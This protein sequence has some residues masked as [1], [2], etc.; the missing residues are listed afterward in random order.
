MI[1]G[2][3]SP[4]IGVA[5]RS[6]ASGAE[7]GLVNFRR[8]ITV[9]RAWLPLM[10]VTAVLA[11]ATA[12]V[13]SSAMPKVYEAET[14]LIVGQ[15]LSAANPDYSQF[16]VD[17]S[18]SS[19]YAAVAK[20]RPILESVI[21]KLG[22]ADTPGELADRVRVDAPQSSS[23]LLIKVQDTDPARAAAIANELGDQLIAASP[24][25]RGRTS[26]V[27]TGVDVDLAATREV[28]ASLQ[29]QAK[30]LSD[31][32]ART[33][34]QD[35][36][37]QA[38]VE[39]LVNIRA[40]YATLLSYASGGEANVLTVIEPAAPTTSPVAP[41]TL[42]NTLLAAVLGL[43][44]VAGI[45][46]LAEQL[47][48]TV[49]D[50]DDVQEVANLGTLGTIARMRDRG[51]DEIYRVVTLLYPRSSIAEAYRALRVNVEFASVD[52]PL[53]TLLVTSAMPGDGKSVTSA[54]LAVAFAQ[55]GRRVLLVDADLRKPGV[56]ALFRLPNDYGLFTMLRGDAVD[57]EAVSHPTEEANLRIL[58]TGPLPPNPAEQLG[59]QRMQAVLEL[60]SQSADLVIF[61]SPPLQSVT[62]SAVLSAFVD[63]T[64]LVVRAGHSRR[65]AVRM[66]RETL[67]RA[68]ANVLGVVLNRVAAKESAHYPSYYGESTGGSAGRPMVP[69][70]AP[71]RS[72][73]SAKPGSTEPP[74]ARVG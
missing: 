16:L 45:A 62:D 40:A 12:F 30:K 8:R 31:L 63:G 34:Q 7:R 25:L 4:G 15:S 71:D 58:T 59:S 65:G 2:K 52:A 68:G 33:P 24:A 56:N 14:T 74:A 67:A 19:T 37:L 43:F 23:F 6:R 49:K 27:L 57:V 64:I 22:L 60:L 10:V 70:S 41:S 26:D 61:D 11:G 69:A 9:V 39:R 48:D 1:I 32:E 17:Q 55:A 42:L 13:V 73:T 44:V 5:A 36:D 18:L 51:R 28:I 72:A 35:S 47:D 29:A 66:A 20:T 38:L 21:D 50:A 3:A 54:N 46:F 53:K